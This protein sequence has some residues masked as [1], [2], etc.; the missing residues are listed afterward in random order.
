MRHESAANVDLIRPMAMDVSL[1][2]GI[3]DRHVLA[4]VADWL[5]A[6]VVLSLPWS[7]SATSILIALWLMAALPALNPAAIRGALFSAAGALPV[8]LLAL[9]AAGMLWA[10]VSWHERLGGLGGFGRLLIIPLLLAQFGRS[11]NGMR[12]LYAFILSATVLLVWSW[13]QSV[14]PNMPGP[15]VEPGV[16]VKDYITQSTEFAICAFALF[17]AAFE[18]GRSRLLAVGL[19]ALA[20][21][22]LAN[23][24]FVVTGR[25]ILLVIPVLALLL[26]WRLFGWKGL[27]AAGLIGCVAGA[28]IWSTS[29]YLRH[30]MAVSMEE[31][32]GYVST[33]A[34]NSTG[35]HLEFLRKAVSFVE[36]APVVGHGTGS[37]RE[38]FSNAAAGNQ[39]AAAVVSVN[40]HNQILTVA[41][42]LGLV[43]A[44]VLI[45][46]WIAHFVLFAGAGLIPWIGTIIVVQN[47]VSSLFN[48]S[49]FDFTEGWIYVF[50]VG[51][52]GGMLRRDRKGTAGASSS[53]DRDWT[54]STVASGRKA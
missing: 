53:E 23:I 6:G 7:T 22:F 43:G 34:A 38:Q 16:P 3:F 28:G 40:P 30:R 4:R 25:T 15:R 36:T 9:A 48:S 54:N 18:L 50:G 11:P 26:G 32:R 29:P 10:D 17:G 45:A 8:L 37:I 35:A 42:Q 33:D 52:V 49:L 2:A 31:F 24:F 27:L 21:L 39:G 12:T 51:I 20:C 13:V 5:A 41:V 19:V 14:F 46:M 47:V 1:G 44:A